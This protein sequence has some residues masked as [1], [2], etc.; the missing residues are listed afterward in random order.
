[1][2]SW[3]SID[4]ALRRQVI[5]IAKRFGI[6]T[7]NVVRKREHVDELKAAGCGTAQPCKG[8]AG[9]GVVR[10]SSEIARRFHSSAGSAYK[11]V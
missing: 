10:L 6:K 5:G 7:I 4:S 3:P 2:A 1:V 8:W 11:P 9:C